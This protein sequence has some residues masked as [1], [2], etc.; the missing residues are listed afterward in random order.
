VARD[1]WARRRRAQ[2]PAA[3]LRSAVVDRTIPAADQANLFADLKKT[4]PTA[5]TKLPT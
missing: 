1:R 2:K 5:E 4:L 3:E